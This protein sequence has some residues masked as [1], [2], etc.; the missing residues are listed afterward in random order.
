MQ[1]GAR[2]KERGGWQSMRNGRRELG[3]DREERMCTRVYTRVYCMPVEEARGGDGRCGEGL[4]RE[5][6]AAR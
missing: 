6:R 2:G 1:K 5:N 4:G 3:E